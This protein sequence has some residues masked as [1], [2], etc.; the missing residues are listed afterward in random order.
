MSANGERFPAQSHDVSLN[1]IGLDM[2]RSAVEGLAHD[3]AQLAPGDSVLVI[4]NYADDPSATLAGRVRFVRRLS[5]QQFVV[6]VWFVDPDP[7][8]EVALERLVNRARRN[9]C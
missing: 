2:M 9:H 4:V 7:I 1:S 6:G 3:G 8:G 5:Q